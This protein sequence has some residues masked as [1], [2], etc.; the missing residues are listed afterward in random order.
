MGGG[1][2]GQENIRQNGGI[3]DPRGSVLHQ[4]DHQL[5][6][7][8]TLESTTLKLWNLII[9]LYQP[10]SAWWR[11]TLLSIGKMIGGGREAAA[12]PHS[13]V[14][15]SPCCCGLVASITEVADWCQGWGGATRALPSK[16]GRLCILVTLPVH[17]E[18]SSNGHR[19]LSMVSTFSGCSSFPW[20][21]LLGDLKA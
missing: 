13:L 7:E 1:E 20:W 18:T 8:N 17:W 12:L 3:R 6:T 2:E 14:L 21:H 9:Y 11:K 5:G 4:N 10:G 19:L 15:T 16:N